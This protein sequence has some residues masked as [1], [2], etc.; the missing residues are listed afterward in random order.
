MIAIWRAIYETKA[1]CRH[2]RSCNTGACSRATRSAAKRTEANKGGCSTG[3]EFG[4]GKGVGPDVPTISA[5][6]RRRGD[7]IASR[8]PPSWTVEDIGAAFVVKDG[9]GQTVGRSD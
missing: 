7:R 1:H 4:S 8:F 2:F 5:R 3:A 9:A 6:H